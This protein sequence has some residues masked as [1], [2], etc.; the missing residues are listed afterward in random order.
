MGRTTVHSLFK[1]LCISATLILSG[2][3][4]IAGHSGTTAPSDSVFMPLAGLLLPVLLILCLFAGAGWMWARSRW[5]AVP[6]IAFLGCW[7]YLSSTVQLGSAPPPIP[8]A[9]RLK[10][11]TYNVA[12]FGRELTGYSCRQI[13][14]RM[15]ADGVDIILFQEFGGNHAFNV[16]SLRHVL[17]HW[18]HSYL[19]Q[20]D[21]NLSHVLPL[22]IFSRYPLVHR[23][24]IIFAGTANS[25]AM[26]DVVL[27]DDTIR[28]F[29][30]HL[31]TTHVSQKRRTWQREL[32]ANETRRDLLVI[33]DASL[34]LHGNFVKR[35]EQTVLLD[36]L[37][38]LSPHP[39]ILG[40]DLNSLPSSHT[41]HVLTSL[42]T[43]GFRTAG[44]GYMYTYRYAKHLLRIDYLLHSPTFRATRYYSP[45]WDFCSDHNPV[46]MEVTPNSNATPQ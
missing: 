9:P 40:G 13:A 30:C 27:P 16:D 7:D 11:G 8:D 22:A 10:V 39:V 45:S 23:Q 25:S 2:I 24:S 15:Q 44:S 21:D 19:P 43:D 6:L 32:D 17:S 1:G 38:R 41:Y 29:N 35:Q 5:A 26:C 36:S 14:Q 4:L 31:Q 12:R 34:T 33:Q 28:L 20:T 46:F 37:I 42:L 18:Q 3:T